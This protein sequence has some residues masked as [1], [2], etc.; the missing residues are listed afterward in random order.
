MKRQSLDKAL[1]KKENKVLNKFKTFGKYVRE[2]W[3]YILGIFLIGIAIYSPLSCC[4]KYHKIYNS[5]VNSY[6]DTINKTYP[7]AK[8][9]EYTIITNSKYDGNTYSIWIKENNG[10]IHNLTIPKSKCTI[11]ITNDSVGKCIVILHKYKGLLAYY[12]A[13]TH[14]SG[15]KEN[16]TYKSWIHRENNE[17]GL[18]DDKPA[19][20]QYNYFNGY[21]IWYKFDAPKLVKYWEEE[22]L[23]TN[24][25]RPTYSIRYFNSQTHIYV[26]QIL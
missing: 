1:F 18:R 17:F 8:T 25:Y 23:W 7:V 14:E 9:L 20:V 3:G 15:S 16:G 12:D 24:S 6:V 13:H 5:Y 19:K 11:H 26:N 10:N 22:Q 4:S 21:E 2:V